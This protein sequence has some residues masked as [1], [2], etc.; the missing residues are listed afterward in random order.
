MVQFVKKNVSS[1]SM[2]SSSFIHKF[3]EMQ[4]GHGSTVALNSYEKTTT[5]DYE[6]GI[7]EAQLLMSERWHEIINLPLSLNELENFKP[8][9][10]LSSKEIN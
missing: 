4:A 7:V 10:Q 3:L 2:L 5:R 6:N 1:T 8:N 9:I